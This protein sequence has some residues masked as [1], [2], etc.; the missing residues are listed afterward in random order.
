MLL[1]G[2]LAHVAGELLYSAGSW[3]LSYELA[4]EH[5][6]GQYQGLFGMA[7]RLAETV[8]PA[9]TAVLIIGLGLPGWLLFG[10][11]LLA[12]GLATPAAARW[13]ERT[14]T[15]PVPSL[16]EVVP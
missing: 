3:A 8:T 13:A 11:L 5:A 2:A 16:Q 15:A 14:R 6:Q 10:A 4:P 1:V 12:A 7:T 9:I